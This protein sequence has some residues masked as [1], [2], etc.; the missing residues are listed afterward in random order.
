MQ[1]N[2][3]HGWLLSTMSMSAEGFLGWLSHLRSWKLFLLASLLFAADLI[4]P[5]PI[6]MIDEIMLGLATLLTA[7]WKRRRG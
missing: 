3:G 6:P 2:A 5:D 7:R 1:Q 4:L